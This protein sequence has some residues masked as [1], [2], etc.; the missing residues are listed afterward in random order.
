VIVAL[1]L[2]TVLAILG[3]VRLPGMLFAHQ[4]SSPGSSTSSPAGVLGEHSH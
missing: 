3:A 2:L 1:A 4:A